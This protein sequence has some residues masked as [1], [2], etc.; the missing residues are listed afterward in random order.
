MLRQDILKQAWNLDVRTRHHGFFQ[1][2]DWSPKE[3]WTQS[4]H[5]RTAQESEEINLANQEN[6]EDLED[7]DNENAVE[8]EEEDQNDTVTSAERL[9]NPVERAIEQDTQSPIAIG[10]QLVDS[11]ITEQ[12]DSQNDIHQQ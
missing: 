9:S 7:L 5:N 10:L 6:I 3:K 2:L 1:T 12:S 4:H 8:T 11:I